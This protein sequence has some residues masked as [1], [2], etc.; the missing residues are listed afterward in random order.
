MDSQFASLAKSYLTSMR[1]R[2]EEKDDEHHQFWIYF[3]FILMLVDLVLIYYHLRVQKLWIKPFWAHCFVIMF[4]LFYQIIPGARQSLFVY[5]FLHTL[6]YLC[7]LGFLI[8]VVH[9]LVMRDSLKKAI[10]FYTIMY[11]TCPSSFVAMLYLV[12]S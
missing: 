3:M 2:L 8:S 10:W 4:A 1:E 7:I 9:F 12:C 5:L 6:S 11:T